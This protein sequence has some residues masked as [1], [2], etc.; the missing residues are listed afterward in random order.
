ME[1]QASGRSVPTANP[2]QCEPCGFAKRAERRYHPRNFSCDD[3]RITSPKSKLDIEY[4]H[5]KMMHRNDDS[6]SRATAPPLLAE[7]EISAAAWIASW[8][9]RLCL[10]DDS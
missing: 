3:T 1:S 5:Y 10:A 9:P 2:V 8:T 7:Y 6:L 4:K